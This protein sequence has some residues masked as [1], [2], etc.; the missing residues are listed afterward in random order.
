M[1]RLGVRPSVRPSRHS[2]ASAAGLLLS[3]VPAGEI[4]ID[5]GGR[6]TQAPTT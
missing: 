3:A 4:S 2:H 6:H 1:K 5:S